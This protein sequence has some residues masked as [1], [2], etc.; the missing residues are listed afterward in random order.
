MQENNYFWKDDIINNGQETGWVFANP[1]GYNTNIPYGGRLSFTCI[2]DFKIS[3]P[4][5]KTCNKP[6]WTKKIRLTPLR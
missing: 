2:G 6:L 1:C 4:I 5:M 3:I